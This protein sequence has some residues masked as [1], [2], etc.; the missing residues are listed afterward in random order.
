MVFLESEHP[1]LES[2]SISF[3]LFEDCSTMGYLG[4]RFEI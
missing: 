2:E 1:C 3:F 4:S